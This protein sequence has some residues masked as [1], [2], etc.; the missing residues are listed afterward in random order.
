MGPDLLSQFGLGSSRAKVFTAYGVIRDKRDR[1]GDRGQVDHRRP[2]RQIEFD[3]FKRGELQAH[4]YTINEVM[5]YEL[6]FGEREKLYWDFF[7][8]DWRLDGVSQNDD[9][10]RILRVPTG[11]SP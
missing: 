9:E 11:V 10:R 6:W 7:S 5:H 2:P 4:D 3:A 8:T 1:H